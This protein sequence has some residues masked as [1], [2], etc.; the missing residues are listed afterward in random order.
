MAHRAIRFM[1]RPRRLGDRDVRLGSTHG[2][3]TQAS[4]SRA[5]RNRHAG[6]RRPPLV[7]DC[8]HPC[9]QYADH[10]DHRPR[11]TDRSI[12]SLGGSA[13]T[14]RRR[15]VDDWC[16]PIDALFV[17]TVRRRPVAAC[18]CRTIAR[19][20]RQRGAPTVR[21]RAKSDELDATSDVFERYD[22]GE[23]GG[24]CFH[25]AGGTS[26]LTHCATSS[27]MLE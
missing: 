24:T 20:R 1:P 6:K 7:D 11:R 21:L 3:Q 2:H 19:S 22:A 13:T 12:A 27:T 18:S 26:L 16:R 14:V 8:A 25:E 5:R 10:N 4:E 9:G 17:V 23:R 15:G